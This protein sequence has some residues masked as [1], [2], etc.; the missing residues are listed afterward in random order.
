MRDAHTTEFEGEVLMAP[1]SAR[2]DHG[3]NLSDEGKSPVSGTYYGAPIHP[4]TLQLLSE[5]T[6]YARRWF[7][8]WFLCRQHQHP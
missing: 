6:L 2:G 4:F 1:K 3:E 5:R 7:L 8:M